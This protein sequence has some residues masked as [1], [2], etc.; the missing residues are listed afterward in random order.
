MKTILLK[1]YLLLEAFTVFWGLPVYV[2]FFPDNIKKI[3]TLLGITIL[4][5]LILVFNKKYKLKNLISFDGV[6]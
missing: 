5:F 4:A 3:P 2:Y 1:I 6:K